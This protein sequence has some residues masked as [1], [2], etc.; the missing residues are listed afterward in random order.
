MVGACGSRRLENCGEVKHCA[1][2]SGDVLWSDQEGVGD[3]NT[4]EM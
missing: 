1:L 3:Q 2:D 4:V